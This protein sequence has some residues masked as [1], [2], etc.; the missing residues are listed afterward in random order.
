MGL[1]QIQ[2]PAFISQQREPRR[3]SRIQR[4]QRTTN[5]VEVLACSGIA[6]QIGGMTKHYI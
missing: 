6:L 5:D 4:K 3:A 1:E 2:S